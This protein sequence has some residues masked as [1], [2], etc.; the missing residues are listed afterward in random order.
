MWK[1]TIRLNLAL[2]VGCLRGFFFGCLG[3]SFPEGI[4]KP[5]YER[6]ILTTGKVCCVQYLLVFRLILGYTG[7]RLILELDT[8][9]LDIASFAVGSNKSLASQSKV[10]GMK[11][12][13]RDGNWHWFLTSPKTYN[14]IKLF[15]RRGLYVSFSTGGL[16]P[17]SWINRMSVG[18]E[19]FHVTI[20]VEKARVLRTNLTMFRP[21]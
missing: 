2:V 9:I 6:T 19:K 11:F 18:R 14:I 15:G 1:H 12:I 21:C 3:Q 13:R 20:Y 7:A 10:L 4:I 5:S 17:G 8:E 16:H